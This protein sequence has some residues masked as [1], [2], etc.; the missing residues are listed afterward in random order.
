VND[1]ARVTLEVPDEA[2]GSRLDRFLA[3]RVEGRTRSALRRLILDGRVRVN[4]DPP[5]KPGLALAPGMIVEI[6][7]PETERDEALAET[8]PVD[9][10]FEDDDLL[11]VNK[12]AGMVVHPGHGRTSGTLV[13]ALLGRGTRLSALG[14]PR[15]PGIV[16]RLDRETSGLLLVAKNDRTHL[17]LSR[18]FA[19]REIHKTYR[20]LVWGRLDPPD[21]SIE[22]AIG[23]SRTDRTRMSVRVRGG[24]S[25]ST[26]YRTLAA[27]SGF[28]LIEIDLETGRTHQIRVHMQ[29]IHHPV[30]GDTRYGGRMWKGIQD[31][32]RRKT[33]REFDRLALHALAL[34]L[35]H[36]TSG[37]TVRFEAPFPEEITRLIAVL[38]QTS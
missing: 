5:S 35:V 32:I 37:E 17:A 16:H 22:R 23:R 9:V 4:G 29:S 10:L 21:G 18:A 24:R 25:A 13:N 36:P 27:L 33:L 11:V 30:V 34:E 2:E 3:D 6:D 38:E 31:P 15:R 1:G 28:T 14:G 20:A 7:I 12:P 8:I 26:H 19:R